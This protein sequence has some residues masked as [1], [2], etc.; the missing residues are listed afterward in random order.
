[1]RI[2]VT[3]AFMMQSVVAGWEIYK[4]TNR[5]IS[6]GYIG[7]AEAIPAIG[8]ALY[9]G[10][11]ADKS[12]KRNLIGRA[13][14]GMLFSSAGLLLV[15]TSWMRGINSDRVTVLLMYFF[16]FC[17]GLCRGFYGPTGS[18][19]IAQL[20]E[21]NILSYA[22]TIS[23]T[24]W[25][26]AAITGSAIGGFLFAD[27]GITVTMTF[28]LLFIF[29]GIV[30]VFLIRSKPVIQAHNTEPVLRRLKEGVHFVFGNKIILGA[31][32][33][34]MF[35]VLFGGAVALLPVFANDILRVGP[36]GL[37]MMRAA[38]SVG[39]AVTMLWLSVRKIPGITGVTLLYAVAGFGLSI[40]FFGISKNYFLSLFLLFLSGSFDSVSVIIR[41]NIIQLL[42][43]DAMRGRVS[44]VNTMFIGS[45][46]EIGAFES[47]VTAQLFGTIPSVILGGSLTLCVVAF[48]AFRSKALKT[49]SY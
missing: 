44:A 8:I 35:S 41:A 1:M 29:C 49:F 17:T 14:T 5:T 48:T 34:D 6:L 32:S 22:A 13:L 7:L 19:F 30:S 47:G 46:N 25:Q 36:Q 40:I 45:S 2:F 33:L 24:V 38:P 11:L 10:H 18:A 20:V 15:T 21:K 28:V 9:A 12:N 43:P 39:A 37:G 31:I 4:I 27:F 26:F 23:S 3:L 16:I 42:T